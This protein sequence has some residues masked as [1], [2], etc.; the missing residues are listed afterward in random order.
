M[1][2]NPTKHD[3]CAQLRAEVTGILAE[4]G[5]AEPLWLETTA[6][7]PGQ[8]AVRA[9]LRARA[10]LI[11]A[12]GGDGTVT[13][14]AEGVAGSGVPLAVLPAGTGNLLARNLSLPLD[15]RAALAVAVTGVDMP[16]DAG[17]VN[18]ARFVVMAGVGF[19]ARVMAATS[20]P[21]KKRLGWLAYP[22]AALGQLWARPMRVRLRADGG[23]AMRRWV[24]GLIVGN[25]GWL[26]GGV[27]LLPDAV[28]DDGV[29]DLIV[30]NARGLAGWL[31]LIADVLLRRR[32]TGRL[33]RSVFRELRV[34]LRRPELWE[35][36]GEVMGR[37]RQLVIG[38]Q[39]G[40]LLVRVPERD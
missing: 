13:A 39:P 17:T 8:G 29:L 18:G 30:L 14:C 40:A 19:D 6:D 38:V 11:L 5:W 21:L 1:V 4:H 24:A 9:A 22:L 34:E 23:P 36:D 37:A 12:Y 27:P 20:E 25:V 15:L 2:V 26:Q 31:A 32:R 10:E 33:A 7:D 16:L 35:L 3:D 28:P